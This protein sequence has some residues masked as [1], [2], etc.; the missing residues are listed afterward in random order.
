MRD[1]TT[2]FA[3]NVLCGKKKLLEFSQVLWVKDAPRFKEICSKA[4]WNE[5]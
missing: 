2:K 5:V 1:M 4:I 3:K